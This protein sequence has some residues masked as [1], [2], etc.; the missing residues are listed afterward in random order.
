MS[1]LATLSTTNLLG[2]S[3]T[4]LASKIGVDAADM[5]I[6]TDI[7]LL[8]PTHHNLTPKGDQ[9]CLRPSKNMFGTYG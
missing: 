8:R 2:A 6:A 4:A 7:L 3:I 9:S 1:L 5:S